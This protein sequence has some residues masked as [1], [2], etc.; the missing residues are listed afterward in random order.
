MTLFHNR[1]KSE[2][3]LILE[4]LLSY[5][6]KPYVRPPLCSTCQHIL[7]ERGLLLGSDCPT[8]VDA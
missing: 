5:K 7:N 1:V 2:G 6:W 8:G 3:E 4:K